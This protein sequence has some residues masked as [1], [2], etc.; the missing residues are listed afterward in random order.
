MK[1]KLG[2]EPAFPFNFE[3]NVP[4]DL[5]PGM[6]KRFYAACMAMQGLIS[7]PNNINIHGFNGTNSKLISELSYKLADELLKQ[8]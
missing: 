5:D 4:V 2:Q 1:E 6:S 3:E 8:E 7:N